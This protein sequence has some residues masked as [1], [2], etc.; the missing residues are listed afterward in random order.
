MS[1]F[2]I[3][4][5]CITVIAFISP[6]ITSVINNKHTLELRKLELSEARELRK[7]E[8]SEA[9]KNEVYS[10]YLKYAGKCIASQKSDEDYSNYKSS[11]AEVY[12]YAPE[13]AWSPMEFLDIAI[14]SDDFNTANDLLFTVAKNLNTKN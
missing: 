1:F 12:L 5:V 4:T 9:R 6:I 8:I 7:L 11:L 3:I 14:Q 13:D 10:N 2:E